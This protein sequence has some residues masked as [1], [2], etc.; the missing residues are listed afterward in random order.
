MAFTLPSRDVVTTINRDGSRNFLHPADVDGQFT[1]ARRLTAVLIMGAYV[2]LPWFKINGHP[3]VFLDVA[4]RRFYLF[5]LT[6]A[7]QD[8][9]LMFFLIT[10][11][12]FTLFFVTALLGRI[13]CGWACPQ[14]IF[15][16]HLYRRFERWLEGPAPNRRRLDSQSWVTPEKLIR[17]GGKA[18]VF[19]LL[20]AIIAHVFLAYFVSIPELYSWMRDEPAQHWSAFLFVGALTGLLY[21]NFAWFRE[22]FCVILCPYG[23]FQSALTDDDTL[24]IGYDAKR[25]EPRGKAADPAAGACVNCLRCVQVCPTGIDIRQGFQ[26]ECI[27]C[28]GCIDACDEVMDKLGRPRGLV[29]YDSLNGLSGKRRRILRP[30]LFL[31]TV[32][33]IVGATVALFSFS[34]LRPVDISIVRM[35]GRPYFITQ[36][37]VRNQFNLRLINKH[38]LPMSLHFALED[39]PAGLRLIGTSNAVILPPG[40][41]IVLP[42][43]LQQSRGGYAGPTQV[44]LQVSG[45][46]QS[47]TQ[48]LHI[49]FLGPDAQLLRA[50]TAAPSAP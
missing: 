6:F 29:R 49:E 28:A 25:G 34:T 37:T 43:V 2:L 19:V 11:L 47:F 15:L 27:G 20:S 31:Y 44:T 4:E 5:G 48:S 8:L 16:E 30:R 50:D 18:V 42:M 26:I 45:S 46:D 17:R 12:G 22:Q 41:E 21:F 7:P 10:G 32:L 36:V 14:T 33:L 9:W 23:R 38:D 24:V 3:A 39:A 13:W 35:G 1:Q 40:E